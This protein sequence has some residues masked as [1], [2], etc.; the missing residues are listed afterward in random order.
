MSKMAEKM[1][2][3]LWTFPITK[4]SKNGNPSLYLSLKEFEL[5]KKEKKNLLRVRVN[6]SFEE[7]SGVHVSGNLV[8]GTTT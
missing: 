5:C 2:H 6:D 8:A 7:F 4:V 3:P 1:G